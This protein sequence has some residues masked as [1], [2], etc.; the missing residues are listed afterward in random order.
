MDVQLWEASL[1]DKTTE[2]I[3]SFAA[4]VPKGMLSLS[5][6]SSSEVI[7]PAGLLLTKK[8]IIDLRKYE[9]AGLALPQTIG[10]VER[11]LSFGDLHDGGDGFRAVDFLA[12]FNKVFNHAIRWQPLR[13]RIML[14]G[15]HLR[16]FGLNMAVYSKSVE[17]IYVSAP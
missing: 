15:T 10:D 14:T 17:E 3:A 5:S 12:T 4:A 8:Q 2:E 11:Y 13:A 16:L 6:G 1:K 7:R 9:A